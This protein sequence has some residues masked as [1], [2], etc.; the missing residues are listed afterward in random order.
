MKSLEVARRLSGQAEMNDPF[1]Y[2]PL[3]S[4]APSLVSQASGCRNKASSVKES[5]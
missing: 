1:T 3:S 4:R 5:T 2:K